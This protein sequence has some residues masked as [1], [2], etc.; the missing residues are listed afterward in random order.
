MEPM[1]EL[2]ETCQQLGAAVKE[3]RDEL[4]VKVGAAVKDA[5]G[6]A[7]LDKIN[8]TIDDL[9]GKK[10]DLEKRMKAAESVH[11]K[12]DE[13]EKQ[14]KTETANREEVE[15]KLNQLRVSGAGGGDADTQ[16][17]AKNNLFLRAAT[18]AYMMGAANLSAE[19]SKS[20][21]EARAECKAMGVTDDTTGGYLAP[22]EYVREIIKGVT[23]QSQVRLIVRVRT[24]GS[25]SIMLPK[26][27]GQFAAQRTSEQGNRSETDGLRYGMVEIDAPEM[28]ALVDISQQNLE[29]SAFDLEA[30]IRLESEEQFAVKE[31]A[32]FVTGTGIGQ[33]EGIVTNAASLATGAIGITNSGSATAIADANGVA[34]GIIT[35]FHAVKT[36][37]AIRGRWLLNRTTLGAVRKLKDTNKQYIWQPGLAQGVPNTIY[38][39]PYTEIPD[40]QSEGANNYPIGFGDWQRCYTLLDRVGM[41]LLRD[42]FTQATSGN[43]RFLMRR[44]VGGRVVLGEAARLLKCST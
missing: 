25:K 43:V 32:E 38:S 36:Q 37:Y 26:R 34:D 17:K 35:L 11:A 22:P 2:K 29:D 16:R 33:C 23:E 44:R 40:M 8:Q 39:A 31:G 41:Q 42:P 24:T 15:R 12:V 30:E 10:E 5:L 1:Q 21:D 28:Y 4:D 3:M 13:L 18:K 9:T 27:T 6:Q 20:L 19:E 14:L 7:K